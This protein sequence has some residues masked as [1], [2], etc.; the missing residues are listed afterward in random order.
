MPFLEICG[1]AMGQKDK[2]NTYK[3]WVEFWSHARMAG[4]M[5]VLAVSGQTSSHVIYG[6]YISFIAYDF[7]V[8][9]FYIFAYKPIEKI[10]FFLNEVVLYV[11][12][13]LFIHYPQTVISSH[14]DFIL[15]VLTLLFELFTIAI[16]IHYRIKV[17][18]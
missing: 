9:K 7:V 14:V 1:Y 4:V 10:V 3:K 17:G 15:L 5:I 2:E 12:A 16:R 18:P 8:F 13:I 6:V 11:M